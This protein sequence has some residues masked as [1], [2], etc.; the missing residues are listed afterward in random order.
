[1]G[2]TCGEGE[3]GGVGR[4]REFRLDKMIKT[5]TK[6]KPVVLFLQSIQAPNGLIC[7]MFGP[8][9]G[10]RHDAFMLAESGVEQKLAQ[11]RKPSGEPYFNTRMSTAGVS[12]E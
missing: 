8:I 4:R 6:L 9:E 3:G 2:T 7:H 5:G 1:M 12:V 10:R 11:I